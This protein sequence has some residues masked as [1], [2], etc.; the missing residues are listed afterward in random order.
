MR[1]HMVDDVKRARESHIET[2]TTQ[3]N[4]IVKH[5]Y[6]WCTTVHRRPACTHSTRVDD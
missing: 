4:E 5:M 6:K 3:K 2:T 1:W